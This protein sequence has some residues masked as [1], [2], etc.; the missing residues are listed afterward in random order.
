MEVY[1]DNMLV[2]SFI[3]EQHLDHLRQAFEVLKKYNMKFNPTKCSFGVSSGKFLGYIVTK[4]GIEAKHDQ[5]LS[6]MG[7][8]SPTCIKDV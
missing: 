7:I 2:K 3:T 4:C 8:P 1:I 5:I 6:V